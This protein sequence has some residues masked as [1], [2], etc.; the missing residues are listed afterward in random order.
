MHQL[1]REFREKF[2]D[3]RKKYLE[4]T[5]SSRRFC[6]NYPKGHNKFPK[7]YVKK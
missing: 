5:T 2:P 4:L 1:Q 6:A 7:K 3:I